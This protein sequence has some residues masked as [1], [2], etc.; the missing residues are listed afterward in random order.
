[1]CNSWKNWTSI[2][3]IYKLYLMMIKN[4]CPY[5]YLPPTG[6]SVRPCIDPSVASEI[7]V[8]TTQFLCNAYMNPVY[9]GS[10]KTLHKNV[11]CYIL[12]E[13]FGGGGPWTYPYTPFHTQVLDNVKCGILDVDKAIFPTENL[14]NSP[15]THMVVTLEPQIPSN[16]SVL[17]DMEPTS[18]EGV[19]FALHENEAFFNVSES[20]LF[21]ECWYIHLVYIVYS[22]TL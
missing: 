4:R 18:D 17:D 3:L 8:E 10:F 2:L 7:Q 16:I 19:S 1:M 20:C 21:S 5:I 22:D 12:N 14:L 11:F 13:G 15:S 6:A 9:D